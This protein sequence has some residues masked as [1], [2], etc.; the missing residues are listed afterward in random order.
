MSESTY[1]FVMENLQ[2]TKWRWPQV[3]AGSGVPCRTLEKI[4]RRE[5]KNPKIQTIEK[6]A[7]YFRDQVAA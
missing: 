7:T 3:A 6:L 4:A 1:D 5:T 2:A